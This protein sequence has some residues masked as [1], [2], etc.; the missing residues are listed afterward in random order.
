MHSS[1]FA[2]GPREEIKM[3][4]QQTERR[5]AGCEVRIEGRKLVGHA[6][7]FNTPTNMGDFTETIAPGA[8]ANSLAGGD[9]LALIDHDTSRLLGRTKSGTLRLR[10]DARGLAFEIDIPDTQAGRDVLALAQR[11][12]LGGASFGF[13]VR[14]GGERWSGEQRT[15]TDVDLLEISVVSAWPAYPATDVSARSRRCVRGS[16]LSRRLALIE[17]GGS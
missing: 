7:V 16:A 11:G 10:E 17:L 8:F 3:Q 14:E 4:T 9:K 6:A 15:L 12:D 1:P 2:A 13:R 5:A